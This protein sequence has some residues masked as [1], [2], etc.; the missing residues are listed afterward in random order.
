MP[1]DLSF[2]DRLPPSSRAR[3]DVLGTARLL[4]AAA[5][6]VLEGDIA[7][8]VWLVRDGLVK[9]VSTHRDGQEPILGLRG[10]GEL[11]GEL[12]MLADAPRSATVTA[13]V[14]TSLQEFGR[15]EFRSWL[16][17]DRDGSEALMA[18]LATRIRE[19]DAFRVSFAGDDVAVRLARILLDLARDHGEPGADGS[20]TIGLPLSQQ[21]LAGLVVASRDAVA[22][23]LQGWRGQGLV[24]TGRRS[25][26]VI[27]PGRLER[28][29]LR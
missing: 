23:T 8:R 3:L 16:R 10:R 13:L 1:D 5:A 14:E 24:E 20:I 11:I 21:D 19:G 25:L 6:L 7:N 4:R 12:G 26:T 27:D 2:S 29:H 9:V 17:S 18:H 15:D 22:K 28:R